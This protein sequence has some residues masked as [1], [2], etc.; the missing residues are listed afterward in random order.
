M[1]FRTSARLCRHVIAAALIATAAPA[2]AG[3]PSRRS[4]RPPDAASVARAREAAAGRLQD[5]ECRRVFSDFRDAHGRTIEDKLQAWA[6]D[7]AE[8]VRSLP[9]VDGLGESRCHA[10]K[11]V[12]AATVNVPRVFVCSGFT[13]LQRDDP[14]LATSLVIH[15]VLHTLGLGEN[16]P[17]SAEI[18]ERVEARCR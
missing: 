4:L 10:G 16:P 2:S 15:E 1:W 3:S 14:G 9:F 13:R 8:Y 7:P 18:T 6:V 17:S 11:V 12:L 5:P